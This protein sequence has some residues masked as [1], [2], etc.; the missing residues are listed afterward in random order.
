MEPFSFVF[1]VHSRNFLSLCRY[2]GIMY[3][4]KK[5]GRVVGRERR[6][7]VTFMDIYS[8]AVRCGAAAVF[9]VVSQGLY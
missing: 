1:S 7:D 5:E 9:R 6:C 4:Y 2:E 8:S 3:I